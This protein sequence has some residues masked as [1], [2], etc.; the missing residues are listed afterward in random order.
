VDRRAFA[1]LDYKGDKTLKGAFLL[2]I[3]KLGGRTILPIEAW[4]FV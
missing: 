3:D 2:Q 1:T 4:L